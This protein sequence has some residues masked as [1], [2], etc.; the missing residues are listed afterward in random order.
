MCDLK[1]LIVASEISPYAKSGGLGDVT[2]SLPKELKKLG[3]DVRVV[4]PKYATIN[5]KF[6]TN[7]NYIDSFIVTLGWRNQNASL[8]SIEDADVPS[9]LIANDYYFGRDGFYGYGDD[10]ERFAFFTKASIEFLNCIDFVPDVIHFNDWQTGLG[11]V[12]LRDNYYGFVSLSKVKSVLTIHNLQY[13]GLFGKEILGT[14]GLNDGYFSADK[15][16]F[17]NC[18]SLLKGGIFYADKVTTVSETY[19]NEIQTPEYGYGMDG[20]LRSQAFKL[21]G[22]VNGIDVAANDPKTDKRIFANYGKGNLEGKKQNKKMLQEKLNLP[23]RNDV[24]IISVISRLV[25]QKGLDLISVAMEELISKDIQFVV[26]GT[27]EGRY[28]NLFKHM[29]W[30]APDKVSANIFFN[31]ELAQQIYAASDMFLMP[32]VFEPCGLGQIFAMQYG[33]VPVV[34]KTGGLADTVTHYNKE[35]K[36]GTGF[37]FENY[38]ARGM[39]WAINEAIK[40][41]S[42]KDEHWAQIIDNGLSQDFSWSKSAEKYIKLYSTLKD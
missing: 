26:L 1:V 31:E 16:E 30:R 18:V 22:I 42:A 15:L 17:N 37:V 14:V 40:V 5:Q 3:V 24:P 32:S 35:T 7:L 4:F 25:D 29:A 20:I 34:R 19:A 33:T 38:D 6:L 2:G 23:I 28:E 12:Y 21:S 39:M 36:K 27:G 8:Y 13:Q 41:Y 9:Y 10:F 11:P